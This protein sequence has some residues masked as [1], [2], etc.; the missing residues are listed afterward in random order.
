MPT[1]GSPKT[2]SVPD[3]G[4]RRPAATLRSVDLPQPVGP[5]TETNS[6]SAIESETSFTAVYGP[7]PRPAKV[8]V[9]PS[10]VTAAV[11]DKRL[12]VFRRR[13][14]RERVVECLREVHLPRGLH[15]G[16]ELH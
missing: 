9:M 5:T 11:M 8:Q 3:E 2:R 13:L 4:L 16:L 12:P 10:K 6:P 1:S 14:L 7:P 15:R